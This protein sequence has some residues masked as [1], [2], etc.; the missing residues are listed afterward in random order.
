MHFVKYKRKGYD[1]EVLPC[2]MLKTD[3]GSDNTKVDFLS[4]PSLLQTSSLIQY[5]V[6]NTLS[7]G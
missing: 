6:R 5:V 1:V 2:G 3:L 4:A 7:A